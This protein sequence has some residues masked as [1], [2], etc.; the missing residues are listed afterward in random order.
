MQLSKAVKR[1]IVPHFLAIFQWALLITSLAFNINFAVVVTGSTASGGMKVIMLFNLLMF[2]LPAV[3]CLMFFTVRK[4]GI[5]E[6]C[7]IGLSVMTLLFS[8]ANISLHFVNGFV[9]LM[10]ATEVIAW[11]LYN[12][13]FSVSVYKISVVFLLPVLGRIEKIGKETLRNEKKSWA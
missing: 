12:I 13:T 2:L 5:A 1:K 10:K 7:I 3:S 6:R 8:V 4:E 11:G 9:L